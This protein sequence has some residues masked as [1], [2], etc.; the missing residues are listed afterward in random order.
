MP[1]APNGTRIR[2]LCLMAE[3]VMNDATHTFLMFAPDFCNLAYKKHPAYETILAAFE[4]PFKGRLAR[5]TV[6]KFEAHLMDH[7]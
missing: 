6:Q 3:A 1:V 7:S 2:N 4:P 5:E